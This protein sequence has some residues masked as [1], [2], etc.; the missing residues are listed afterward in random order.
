MSNSNVYKWCYVGVSYVGNYKINIWFVV[1][2][3]KLQLLGIAVLKNGVKSTQRMWIWHNINP[4][5]LVLT[6][7]LSWGK[8]LDNPY[9][10]LLSVKNK[11]RLN[12]YFERNN[13]P[14]YGF[15]ISFHTWLVWILF[16]W[17]YEYYLNISLA[18]TNSYKED[19]E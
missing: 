9:S 11:I 5:P 19:I 13:V 6:F 4:N 10:I 17:L 1:S 3:G 14:I 7:G 16:S 15:I 18:A 8:I 12:W 2:W